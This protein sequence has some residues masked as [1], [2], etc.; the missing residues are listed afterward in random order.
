LTLLC[1]QHP[2]PDFWRSAA[3]DPQFGKVELP[4]VNPIGAK[5]WTGSGFDAAMILFD[6]VVLIS[7]GSPFHRFRQFAGSLHFP[8]RPVRSRIAIEGDRTWRRSL[9]FKCL[10][11]ERFGGRLPEPESNGR[12]RL[13][14][15]CDALGE[16]AWGA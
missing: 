16:A 10:A 3:F 1:V 2:I 4:S 15:P 13:Q 7:G 14:I 11:K 5:H 12:R 9:A 6:H 8:H